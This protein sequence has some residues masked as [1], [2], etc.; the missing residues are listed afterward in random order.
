[1][2]R[3]HVFLLCL[4]MFPL[5]LGCERQNYISDPQQV[6]SCLQRKEIRDIVAEMDGTSEMP[7]RVEIIEEIQPQSGMDQP[8]YFLFWGGNVFWILKTNG[9]AG[10]SLW[11]GP[12]R[13]SP[14]CVVEMLES[15]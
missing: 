14:D 7:D 13:M 4:T 3:V 15:H 5:M 11:Y 2:Y 8:R 9:L 6:L 12:A 10:T 1:M